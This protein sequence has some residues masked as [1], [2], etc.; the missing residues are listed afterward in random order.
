MNNPIR[1][2]NE[3]FDAALDPVHACEAG[4]APEG[5]DLCR[6]EAAV[7]WFESCRSS[8]SIVADDGCEL[9]GWFLDQWN[10]KHDYL[11][12]CHGYTG[13]P[14]DMSSFARHA[15]D[16]GFKVLLPAARGHERNRESGYI[17]MGW[18]DS[19]D[20][21]IWIQMLHTLD[22]QAHIVLA[23]VSMGAAEVMM[24]CGRALPPYVCC[25]IEDCGYTSVWDELCH[26]S[27]M[28]LGRK[29][30]GLLG[31]GVLTACDAIVRARAGFGL[32]E[33]SAVRQLRH[34]RI[35]VL[36]IHGTEDT[37]V[38]FSMLDEVFRACGSPHKERLA[39]EG[40][41]HAQSALVDPARYWGT[42]DAFVAQHLGTIK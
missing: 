39:I 5:G 14:S 31:A 7:R 36:F 24:A 38:P 16:R 9:F 13:R 17:Q 21:L 28:I 42:I 35:P 22:P 10:G 2:L 3:L 33:A 40:A 30:K 23:G 11:I 6:D 8:V 15:F 18:Q 32:R 1:A 12:A 34:A 25:A 26:L 4:I 27:E 41:A 29:A 37:F 19:A 20:L